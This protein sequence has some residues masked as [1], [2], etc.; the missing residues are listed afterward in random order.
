MEDYEAALAGLTNAG[1]VFVGEYSTEPV[2]DYFCGSNQILPT[3]GTARFS[4][5]MSVQEFVRGYSVIKY[6]EA[7][8]KSNAGSIITLA[9]S[10][11]MR[12]HAL[13][14]RVRN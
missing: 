8:L 5:G 3:C 7:A 13:A 4:S 10:E 2:G 12:A 6:P 9:E 1:A 14:I 11:G